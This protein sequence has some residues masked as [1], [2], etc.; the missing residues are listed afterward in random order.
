MV[1]QLHFAGYLAALHAVRP[2]VVVTVGC[3][4]FCKRCWD[5]ERLP[6][7]LSAAF[8]AHC[9]GTT[10]LRGSPRITPTCERG[11]WIPPCP[12]TRPTFLSILA[13]FSY[14]AFPH[15]STMVITSIG[16]GSIFVRFEE[17]IVCIPCLVVGGIIWLSVP[18]AAH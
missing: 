17:C 18:P 1:C 3:S 4:S 5:L 15:L 13:S 9:P 2:L 16:Y 14:A 11:C 12:F 8:A 6:A 10:L 7:N